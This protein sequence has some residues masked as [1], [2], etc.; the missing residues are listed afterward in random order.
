M[1]D[2]RESENT[3]RALV[4]HAEESRSGPSARAVLAGAVIASRYRVRRE[5]GTG[6]MGRVYLSQRVSDGREVV[7]KMVSGATR[8]CRDILRAEARVLAQLDHPN[9]VGFVEHGETPDCSFIAMEAVRGEDLGARIDRAHITRGAAMLSLYDVATALDHT[10]A[11]GFVH[12]DVK[13]A[14]V[15]IDDASGRQRGVLIDFGLATPWRPGA[16][17]ERGSAFVLGTPEYMAPEQAL[18]LEAD[19]GPATDRYALA[20]IALELLTGRRPYPPMPLGRLLVSIIE[21]PPRRPSALGLDS[22]ALDLVFARAMARDPRRRYESAREQIDAIVRALPVA[23]AP[24]RAP[25][26]GRTARTVRAKAA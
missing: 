13:P 2:N 8:R 18:G 10:H 17:S 23:R 21:E 24:I 22:R 1:T 7:L 11:R 5:I 14:N 20:A 15:M 16:R 4:E 19:I 25:R 26:D 6:A 12:R 9:V 3:I